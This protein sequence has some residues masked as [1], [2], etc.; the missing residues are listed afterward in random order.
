VTIVDPAPPLLVGQPLAGLDLAGNRQVSAQQPPPAPIKTPPPRQ[1]DELEIRA[2]MQRLLRK[3][4]EAFAAGDYKSA[5]GQYQQAVAT[6]P[7]EPMGYFHLAQAHL[8]VGKLAEAG[9]AIERGMRLHPN[10]PK[11]PFQPRALYGDQ[12]GDFQRHL[13]ALAEQVGRNMN[14]ESLLFLLAY[15]L[16]FDGQRAEATLLFERAGALAHD[17]TLIDRF[18][19]V[20][21]V[22]AREGDAP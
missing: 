4:N 17:T 22:A 18:L 14:D 16:W 12:A 7:L 2:D 5:L 19:K 9:V 8:A 1:R 20:A 6:A 21:R 15:Q 3:G 13:G 11:A 10:W